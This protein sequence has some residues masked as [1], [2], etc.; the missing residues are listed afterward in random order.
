MISCL[1]RCGSIQA[2]GQRLSLGRMTSTSEACGKLFK[3]MPQLSLLLWPVIQFWPSITMVN[4]SSR[5]HSLDHPGTLRAIFITDTWQSLGGREA[6][7][8]SGREP[9]SLELQLQI[10]DS[11][12]LDIIFTRLV[13]EKKS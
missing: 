11:Q 3:T 10:K 1:K 6:G 7:R 13:L 4:K 8:E 12:Y 2:Q 5:R 9:V